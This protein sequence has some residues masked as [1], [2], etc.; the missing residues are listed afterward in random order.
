MGPLLILK[1]GYRQTGTRTK[2]SSSFHNWR[3]QNARRGLCYVNAGNIR[4]AITGTTSQHQQTSVIMF[5]VVE[6]LVPAIPPDDF[7]KPQEPKRQIKSKKYKDY[8]SKNLVDRHSVNNNKCFVT[9]NCKTEQLK[10][11]FFARTVVE[12]NHL[13]TEIVHAKK[14]FKDSLQRRSLSPVYN[15]VTSPTLYKAEA[16]AVAEVLLLFETD[17]KVHSTPRFAIFLRI[18]NHSMAPC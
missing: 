8:I 12:W 17:Q 4:T 11:S 7:L 2:T 13:D 10:Q 18:D 15:A 9:E 3:L 5:K 1:T 16:E 14:D 6:G